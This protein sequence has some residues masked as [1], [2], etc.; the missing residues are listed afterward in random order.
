M[1]HVLYSQERAVLLPGRAGFWAR[2]ERCV[3][4]T[5]DLQSEMGLRISVGTWFDPPE[6]AHLAE[7]EG[8][9]HPGYTSYHESETYSTRVHRRLDVTP[10]P[11]Q[12]QLQQ[13][14]VDPIVLACWHM[15]VS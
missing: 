13:M 8:Q 14:V 6:H 10:R 9:H 3:I 2:G 12:R 1:A 15:T 5:I 4:L 7:V 11:Q